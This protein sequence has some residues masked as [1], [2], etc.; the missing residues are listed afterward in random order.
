MSLTPLGV[1]KQMK[2]LSIGAAALTLSG[3][4]VAS[5]TDYSSFDRD[6]EALVQGRRWTNTGPHISGY[7]QVRL[8]QQWR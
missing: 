8:W 2:L 5:E 7:M 3:F 4:A 6:I 1:S